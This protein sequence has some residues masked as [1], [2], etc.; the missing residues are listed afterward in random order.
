[1]SNR[2]NFLK[3][4]A[5]AAAASPLLKPLSAVKKPQ[6]AS[7]GPRRRIIWNNDGGDLS[8]VALD[9]PRPGW[10]QQYSSVQQFLSRRMEH[11]IGTQVD[12]VTYCGFHDV[13]NWEY[14]R[15]NTPGL[16]PDPLQHVV[17]FCHSNDMEFLYSMRMND[18]HAA[19]YPGENYWSQFKLENPNLLQARISQK[20][21]QKH[22]LPW[23]QKKDPSHPL[24]HLLEYWG[25]M[26][27][28]RIID[29]FRNSNLGP[30]G[31]SWPAFDFARTKVRDHYLT[32]IDEACRRYDL[33]GVEL[34]WGRHP[35]VFRYGEERKNIPILN[36]FIRQIR[37]LL[38]KHEKKRN[39][40]ILLTT[41]IPD[42]PKLSQSI[43]L[44]AETW[45]G[46]GWIDFLIAGFGSSPFSFPIQ[47]W[48]RLGQQHGVPVYGG[49]TWTKLFD[50]V[51]AIHAAAYRL[52]EADVDGI[53]FFNLLSPNY[54]GCLKEIGD[55]RLLARKNKLYRIDPNR[56]KVGYM[57]NSLWPGQLPLALT[58]QSG[59]NRTELRLEISDR[60]ES[61]HSTTVQMGWEAGVDEKRLHWKINGLP[62]SKG[63]RIPPPVDGGE[64]QWWEF[65]TKG[66]KK[67][68]NT[69]ELTV[70]A[71]ANSDT[72]RPVVLNQLRMTINYPN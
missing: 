3:S 57:N 28:G 43:G 58:C 35:L 44:D 64:N 45:M 61:A 41:R 68:I 8:K 2:R 19:V 42:S 59:A 27:D 39:R 30:L 71:P 69:L 62:L 20:A 50:R 18:V 9:F 5:A 47:E 11:L 21:F 16:G 12:S 38:E 46:E 66:A 7:K 32:I 60:P 22:F 17:T 53:Y 55:P 31:F 48:V 56:K 37:Q 34:D 52:W 10:P 65:A 70:S 36:D 23:I 24:D 49:L 4:W 54:Y 63:R 13:A 33:D 67:G 72:A 6:K 29:R 14:P 40:P 25:D 26:D 51:E 1:M 15:K